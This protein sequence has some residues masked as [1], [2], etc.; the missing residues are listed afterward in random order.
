MVYAILNYD[1]FG[2]PAMPLGD[3]AC[4]LLAFLRPREWPLYQASCEAGGRRTVGKPIDFRKAMRQNSGSFSHY[5][6]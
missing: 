6:P 2:D 3:V 4:C 1:A 5:V